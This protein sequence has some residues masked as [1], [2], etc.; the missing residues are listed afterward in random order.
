MRQI[1]ERAR[2]SPQARP[3]YLFHKVEIGRTEVKT[4]AIKYDGTSAFVYLPQ[5]AA[6]GAL[7]A[8][9]Q[10]VAMQVDVAEL[11]HSVSIDDEFL[12]HRFYFQ[13]NLSMKSYRFSICS[14][15]FTVV[16]T[17]IWSTGATDLPLVDGHSTRPKPLGLPVFTKLM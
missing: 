9:S 3:I 1:E 6:V 12:K 2:G 7:L 4:S 13:N 16:L 8:W 11:Q 5:S 10:H 14:S 15:A 17:S